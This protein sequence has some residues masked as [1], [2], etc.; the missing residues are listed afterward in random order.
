[1]RRSQISFEFI[2][3]F[4]IAVFMLLLVLSI[5]PG[6]LERAKTT[7]NAADNTAKEVKMRVITA[8]L[9]RTDYE[10]TYILP[11]KIDEAVIVVEVYAED[12]M[13][14]V[15][16]DVSKHTLARSHLPEID[17]ASGSGSKLTIS[18]V[19]NK[20]SITQENPET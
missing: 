14:L 3:L 9:S 16:D 7:R 8:S 10:A 2:L 6:I 15:K 13:L 1:M 11:D 18:K 17:E 19:A 20:L 12:N 5:L 4:A